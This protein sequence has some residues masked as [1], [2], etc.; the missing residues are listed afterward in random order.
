[1][2]CADVKIVQNAM[3]THIG[4]PTYNPVADLNND[5]QINVRDLAMITKQLPSGTMCP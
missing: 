5:N 2:N 3:N 1:M 4:Q